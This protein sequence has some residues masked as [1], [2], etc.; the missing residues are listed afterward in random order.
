M[1]RISV[2]IVTMVLLSSCGG[3]KWLDLSPYGL[4]AE[5]EVPAGVRINA[6]DLVVMK[7]INLRKGRF[8]MQLFIKP[9]SGDSL[10]VMMDNHLSYVN[11]LPGMQEMFYLDGRSMK[12]KTTSD[13]GEVVYG[14]RY[15]TIVDS[16][17]VV[18][19][20]HM[21]YHY[22]RRH[23]ERMYRAAASFRENQTRL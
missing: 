10:H 9:W 17:E 8:N 21:G 23:M 13:R 16:T 12:Y 14:F 22:S 19:Q 15:L 11:G 4:P 18:I 3:K 20:D 7:E 5:I 1:M 2:A 6:I